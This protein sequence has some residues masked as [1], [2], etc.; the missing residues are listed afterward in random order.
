[1]YMYVHTCVYVSDP[2]VSRL[3]A[4]ASVI[5][6]L[7][8]TGYVPQKSPIIRGSFA[9]RIGDNGVCLYMQVSV[10]QIRRPLSVKHVQGG[11]DTLDALSLRVI[12]RRRAL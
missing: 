6:C 3:Q 7:I 1:M 9:E 5:G 10:G 2:M 8:F 4:T 12:F 11:T